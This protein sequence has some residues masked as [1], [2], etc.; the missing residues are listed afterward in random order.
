VNTN[1][2]QTERP[3]PTDARIVVVGAGMAGLGAAHR[4]L[5]AGI[6]D[7]VVLER[8]DRVGGTWRDNDYPGCA[9]DV[10]S[11]FYSYS[12]APKHDWSHSFARQP[13]LLAYLED[14]A[15][16]PRI[17]ERLHLN[18]GLTSAEWSDERRRWT[19]QTPKGAISAQLLVPAVGILNRPSTPDIPG[20]ESFSGKVFHTTAWDHDYSLTGKRVAVIGTGSTASQVIPAI[21]ADVGQLTVF[22]RSAGWVLPRIDWKV[23]R[24]EKL[25]MKYVPGLQKVRRWRQHWL[26]EVLLLPALLKP[27]R[28]IAAIEALCRWHLRRQVPDAAIRAKLTPKNT[29]GCKRPIMSSDYLRT[30]MRNN[31]ELVTEAITEVRPNAVVTADG[32]EHEIDVLV[33]AT[34][35]KPYEWADAARV[36]GRNGTTLDHDWRKHGARSYLGGAVHGFPNL[37]YVVGPNTAVFTSILFMIERFI[38]HFVTVVQEM[39]RRGLEVVE[40]R[41]DAQDEFGDEMDRRLDGTVW[42][43]GCTSWLLPES[44]HNSTL[45]PGN[46]TEIAGRLRHFDPLAYDTATADGSTPEGLPRVPQFI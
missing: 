6:D 1:S 25:L 22:Q 35:F 18:C 41:S 20:L 10:P 16:Q 8:A 38:E 12:F 26:R 44:Q 46:T 43:S 15:T 39:D 3:L 30:F 40:A 11:A 7:F 31:V 5:E 4:L 27:G 45:W 19:V 17:A 29:F 23:P 28:D 34:G 32:R 37:F 24:I 13:E 2:A 21:A 42:T 9:V 33:L 14:F 36:V